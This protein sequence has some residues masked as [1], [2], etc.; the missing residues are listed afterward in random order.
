MPQLPT[1]SPWTIRSP[2]I[3]A[4][5][6]RL[7]TLRDRH[8]PRRP[9]PISDRLAQHKPSRPLALPTPTASLS[10]TLLSHRP[11]DLFPLLAITRSPILVAIALPRPL[12]PSL[13]PNMLPQLQLS[14]VWADSPPFEAY[15]LLQS[16]PS[17]RRRI[18]LFL[19]CPLVRCA[20]PLVLFPSRSIKRP[21]SSILSSTAHAYSWPS[22][23]PS[24]FSS[25]SLLPSPSL[26]E[27][28]R[29]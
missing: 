1:T 13:G 27:S 16:G 29:P 9:C 17:I 25:L 18:F 4:L 14:P 5:G 12:A 21:Q 3:H 23:S 15:C 6:C 7:A 11:P 10:A 22:S 2:F 8:P 19:Y 20:V 28:D 26:W 24:P